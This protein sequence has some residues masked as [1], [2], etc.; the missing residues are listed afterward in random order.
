MSPI[1]Q[2]LR[3]KLTEEQFLAATDRTNEILCLACAGSGKSR[4]LAYRIA[5]LIA[6]GEDPAG[7]VAFTFTEKAAESIK[8]RVAEALTAS[9]FEVSVLGA[10]YI[11]TIHSYCKLLLGEMDA[12]YRQFDVL[13]SNKLN[14]YLMSRYASLHI[15]A[16][17]TAKSTPARTPGY[18]ECI[19]EVAKAWSIL[20]DELLNLD[21]IVRE[22]PHVGNVLRALNDRLLIDQFLDFSLMIR[23][24]VN[25]LRSDD[26]KINSAVQKIRHLMVDEYQDVNPAQEA[27][28]RGIHQRSES[29][30]VVGDDDQAIY[31]WRGAD[32]TNI[33]EFQTRYE[34]CA[35]HTLSTNFR[36]ARP[37][38]D[39]SATFVARQL[40]PSRI[41]KSPTTDVR[42][43]TRPRHFGKVWFNN[44]NEEAAWVANRINFL[45]GKS[46]QE[47]DGTVRGLTPGDFAVLMSSTNAHEADHTTRHSA[48]TRALDSVG[49][50]YSIEAEGSIFN[51]PQAQVLRDT[52]GLLRDTPLNRNEVQSHFRTSIVPCFPNA[53]FTRVVQILTRWNRLIHEPI[54][55]VRRKVYPQQLLHEMLNSFGIQRSD[56]NDTEMQVLGIFSKIMQDVESVYMSIDSTERFRDILN[57]LNWLAEDGYETSPDEVLQRPDAVFVSTVHKAKGLEFPVVFVVDVEQR[58]FP[59]DERG[60]N[61]WLPRSLLRRALDRGAYR[62]TREGDVRLFY[63]AITRAERYLYISGCESLPG[64]TQRRRRSVFANELTHAEI[65]E[66]PDELPRDLTEATPQRRIDE[67]IVPTNFSE[68]RYYFICPKSYQY[69]KQYGFSP[70]VPELFGYGLTV[71]TAI[72]K[73]HEIYSD[74]PPSI[75]QAEETTR[76]VFNLKH[77]FQSRDPEN[78]PGPYERAR[79]AAATVVKSYVQHYQQDFTNERQVEV[80]FEIPARQAVISGAI[81]L[82]IKEDAGG[83][84]TETKIIDFKSLKEPEE[85][86]LLDWVELSIQ[87]QLYARAALEVLGENAKTGAVHLLRDNLRVEVPITDEAIT[88]AM[89]NVE[90][91]VDRIINRDYPMRPFVNKCTACDFK[92]ICP[93]IAQNFNTGGTPPPVHVPSSVST[94]PLMIKTF[95]QYEES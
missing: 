80:R 83:N 3:E 42:N 10:M 36:S 70:P 55:D 17:R 43:L 61:G 75:R 20:N 86:D 79:D 82:L 35:T 69:R 92:L 51:H 26:A 58:R 44:R 50:L 2:I 74:I 62:N 27:L 7:I 91:A 11:G 84:I 1:E 87:V 95:S 65:T 68:I 37:I 33:L 30:F 73:L 38:I 56:F 9:G 23:L 13:D 46:Y 76:D 29:L 52:L 66:N 31:S 67:T 41:L 45:L 48:F 12:R 60:Y 47:N 6:E 81:D 85:N 64:G 15:R 16:L 54:T 88:A 28:I 22:D 89:Q 4:T 94:S 90:W 14:L 32:V 49:I 34:G 71:H 5:R 63:T 24:V 21:D 8:R 59:G 39:S 78:A 72:G 18:F 40:G 57:F 19:K 25:A 77:V 53:D 93:Q